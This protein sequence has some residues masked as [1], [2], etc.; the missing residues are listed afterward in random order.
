MQPEKGQKPI[1]FSDLQF[2]SLSGR[3]STKI[4]KLRAYLPQQN[5]RAEM[6]MPT[7]Q[8]MGVNYFLQGTTFSKP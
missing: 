8:M 2:R 4:E 5:V 7:M 6:H 1:N 3:L